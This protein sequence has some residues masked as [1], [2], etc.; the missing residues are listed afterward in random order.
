MIE[1]KKLAFFSFL[2]FVVFTIVGDA[3]IYFLDGEVFKSDFK[4]TVDIKEESLKQQYIQDLKKYSDQLDLKFCVATSDITSKNTANYNVYSFAED[5]DFF[6]KRILVN[7]DV[8]NFKSLISGERNIKIKS[9]DET[10][11]LENVTYNVF[12]AKENVEKLRTLTIDKYAMSKP[13][14][15]GYSNDA[16][17]MLATAWGLAT[18]ILI[19]ST[20]FEVNNYK[21]EALVRYLNGTSKK[22]VIKPLV[23]KNAITILCSAL[24]GMLLALLITESY[25][26]LGISILGLAVI[27][28]LTSCLYCN[29]ANL[30]VKKTFVRSYYTFGYKVLSFFVLAVISLML[31]LSLTL[32]YKNIYDAILTIDQ[33]D[34]WEKFYDYDS[35]LFLSKEETEKANMTTD[36]KY[37]I[38]FY[39]ENLDKY[40]MHLSFDFENNSGI[41]SSM[42]D[43]KEPIVYLNKY[44]SDELKDVGVNQTELQENKYYIISPYS[45]KEVIEKGI[46][47]EMERLMNESDIEDNQID[48]EFLTMENNYE[49]LIHDINMSNLA[50]N[51]KKNPIILYDSHSKFPDIMSGYVFNSL[52]KFNDTND[53]KN[54][55]QSIDYQ[56]E[57][58]YQSN[59]KMLYM[60]KQETKIL[61]LIINIILSSMIML[62]YV[63][64]LSTILK[65]DFNSRAVEV[66]LDKVFGKTLYQRYRGLFRLLASSFG[67]SVLISLV[68]E[69]IFSNFSLLYIIFASATMLICT[70]IVVSIFIN[71]YERKSIAKVLKGGA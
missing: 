29:L 56:N 31:I 43:T 55:I 35:V 14:E 53:F 17:G 46:Y 54:F 27:I 41:S 50:D 49:I 51:Y 9:F 59:V 67:L 7:D 21:K 60:E 25:K 11:D 62:L 45:E 6:K 2:F 18:F 64:S 12:G 22:D 69:I 38:Q 26:F 71:R 36:E 52:A 39:N 8:S 66:A 3:Y 10:A 24:I 68:G 44:A 30:D 57:T 40:K 37:A 61:L 1:K 20:I 23:I 15:N 33:S 5:K 63:I 16:F 70:I 65:L 48:F 47:D 42:V 4:Y 28:L 19:I 34:K 32:N 58:Y 13:E